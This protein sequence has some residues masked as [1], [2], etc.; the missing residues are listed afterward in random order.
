MV[1]NDWINLFKQRKYWVKVRKCWL[2]AFH[3]FPKII[4]SPI[5]FTVNKGLNNMLSLAFQS[6]SV[7]LYDYAGLGGFTE[8]Q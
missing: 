8:K 2:P 3:P 6:V 7:T 4:S 5:F 1:H